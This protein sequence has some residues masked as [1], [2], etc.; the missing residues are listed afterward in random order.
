VH[1]AARLELKAAEEHPQAFNLLLKASHD[2]F[3]RFVAKYRAF[4]NF[5]FSS[6][7]MARTAA[8]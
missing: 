6:F 4:M 5:W 1:R 2:F 3:V 8:R 7:E